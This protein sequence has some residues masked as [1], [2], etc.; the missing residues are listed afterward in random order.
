MGFLGGARPVADGVVEQL[1][2]YTCRLL[3]AHR[4]LHSRSVKSADVASGAADVTEELR[5]K[6]GS[7]P[8]AEGD[9]VT[10]RDGK[11]S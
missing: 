2:L 9:A 10:A 3:H 6:P 1:A 8:P 11:P 7:A 4:G 5:S